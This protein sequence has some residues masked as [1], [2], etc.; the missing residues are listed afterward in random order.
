MYMFLKLLSVQLCF[1]KIKKD[2]LILPGLTIRTAM[3]LSFF[4]A[5]KP[6]GQVGTE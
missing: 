5:Q 1:K 2:F 4:L 3:T 6:A